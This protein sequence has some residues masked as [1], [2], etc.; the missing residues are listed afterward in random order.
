VSHAQLTQLDPPIPVKVVR[1]RAPG[2]H[3]SWPEGTGYAVAL[4]DYSQEHNMLWKVIFDDSGEIWDIPQP[5]IRGA[6]NV[7]MERV[8]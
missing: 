3:R 2:S 8:S 1:S 6:H 4:I 7:S 5:Y